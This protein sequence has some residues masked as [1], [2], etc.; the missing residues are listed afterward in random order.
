[1]EGPA[2]VKPH[3][4][5]VAGGRDLPPPRQKV[6]G[7]RAQH[8]SGA[9][10]PASGT[11][12]PM[13]PVLASNLTALLGRSIPI[14]AGAA[15]L[16]PGYNPLL[17]PPVLG[18]FLPTGSRA[19]ERTSAPTFSSSLLMAHSLEL[20][21]MCPLILANSS[22]S[23]GIPRHCCPPNPVL[24]PLGIEWSVRIVAEEN[25]LRKSVEQVPPSLG[26]L[27]IPS[28]PGAE[29]IVLVLPLLQ[30]WSNQ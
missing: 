25:T 30:G 15:E 23:Q 17:S 12:P 29:K 20:A 19:G 18:K 22:R 6:N 1:M 16:R 7:N 3:C 28:F 5:F 11:A 14:Q 4:G 21:G 8:I 10:V 9:L 24:E 26:E 13:L 27:A 2:D